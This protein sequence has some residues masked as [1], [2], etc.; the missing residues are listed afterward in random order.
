MADSDLSLPALP[1]SPHKRVNEPFGPNTRAIQQG[2]VESE[3][4]RR[5]AMER[6]ATPP[7]A[8]ARGTT[9]AGEMASNWR[10]FTSLGKSLGSR[11]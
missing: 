5:R 4:L 11:R 10:K 2:A 6:P 7:T 8:K 9:K 3:R 1:P